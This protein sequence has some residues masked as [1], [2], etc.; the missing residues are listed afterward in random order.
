MQQEVLAALQS[1]LDQSVG[2]GVPGISAAVHTQ[3]AQWNFFAGCSDIF[4]KTP[5]GD[6]TTFG[7]GSIT[8]LFVAVVIFQLV[9]EK[10]FRLEDQAIS[11]LDTN[12]LDD[13]P[14]AAETSIRRLLSHRGGI[15]SW[16][17]EPKWIV[18]GRGKNI[19]AQKIWK[20]EET[21]DYVRRPGDP[22]LTVGK[23]SYANTNYTILGLIIQRVTGNTA[24]AEIR[25]RILQPLNMGSTYV[26]GFE[27]PL[28]DQTPHRYHWAT[29][30]FRRTAGISP[31][32]FSQVRADLVDVTGTN[33]S[34][35]WMA[36]GMISN[37]KDLLK[38][39]VAL[40]N[41][42]LLDPASMNNF[43]EWHE[44][45]ENMDMGHGIFRLK[46][47]DLPGIW[48]GHNGGVLGFTAALWWNVDG[49]CAVSI[50]SNV[51]ASHAHPV[52]SSAARVAIAT[53][54][55]QL[56]AKLAAP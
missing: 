31:K 52:P 18:D 26:E 15:P 45:D 43:M 50:L 7:I 6:E 48:V 13:I 25:R 49:S 4:T 39:A 44:A 55:L 51:G 36:G 40:Q 19:D 24:E 46:R 42:A 30:N 32:Y 33:L 9:Q 21:L 29:E 54:F 41:G 16:E 34:V 20:K 17:D 12:I 1:I 11:I 8:K 47:A 14:H 37:P 5:I 35:S 3:Q 22:G 10:K 28:S 27:Q 53:D 56:S 2:S 23:F 38:F